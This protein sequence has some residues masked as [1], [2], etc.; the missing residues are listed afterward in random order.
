MRHGPTALLMALAGAFF[1]TVFVAQDVRPN[2]D[3]SW[4]T[5]PWAL[6][7][8]YGLAMTLGGLLAGFLFGG[9]F[10]RQGPLGWLLAVIAGV[11]AV[12]LS[13][14]LGSAV[15]L[16]PDLLADGYQSRDLIAVASG[17]LI[18]PLALADQPWLLAVLVL[19]IGA[20]HV[21]A[22]RRRAAG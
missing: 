6:L 19:L 3:L 14:L 10:G 1:F 7:A 13:G 21:I 15:G 17:V 22:R 8:R 9:L 12:A 11:L 16:L 20:A 18:L 4:R 5:L 2:E